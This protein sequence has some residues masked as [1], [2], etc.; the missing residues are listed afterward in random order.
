MQF[1]HDE[2]EF[3]TDIRCGD[4]LID[5]LQEVRELPKRKTCD[6]INRFLQKHSHRVGILYGLPGT[7]KNT[8]MLQIIEGMSDEEFDRTAYIEIAEQDTMPELEED[9]KALW[10][11]GYRHIF[12]HEITRMPDFINTSS[13]L[14]DNYAMMGMKI[15]LSGSDSLSFRFAADDQLYDRVTMFRTTNISYE[16]HSTVLGECSTEEYLRSGGTLCGDNNPFRNR[17]AA[18]E[19]IRKAVCENLTCSFGKYDCRNDYR[20]LNS[21]L[22][23]GLLE[24]ATKCVIKEMANKYAKASIGTEHDEISELLD[25]QI[26]LLQKEK[27]ALG[28]TERQAEVIL[29]F[30]REMDVLSLHPDDAESFPY[31]RNPRYLFVQPGMCYRLTEHLVTGYTH[32]QAETILDAVQSRLCAERGLTDISRDETQGFHPTL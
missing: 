19:Y 14:S 7:G 13:D 10:R 9:L 24:K 23:N 17:K 3:H 28:V 27:E 22:E 20:K 8:I 21:L 6:R 18:I 1:G 5:M 26:E 16:E 12:I 2:N 11:M 15:I 32:A 30:L 4:A 29:Q 25:G 31:I